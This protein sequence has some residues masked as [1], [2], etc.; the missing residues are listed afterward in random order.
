MPKRFAQNNNQPFRPRPEPR[1]TSYQFEADVLEGLESIALD[2]IREKLGRN[3]SALQQNKPGK[4]RFRFA[5]QPR[6]LLGLQ[7][8][9]A[10]YRSQIF[11]VPRP[12][13]LLGHQHFTAILDM[14]GF[15][16][17]LHPAKAFA[18]MRINAAG[19]ESSV[20]LRLR[21]ELATNTGL[22]DSTEND[23]GDLLIRLRKNPQGPG[24]EVLVRISPRPLG[25]RAW[26]VCNRPAAPNGTL[27]YAM[28]RLS[29]PNA[30]DKLLNIGCG[31]GT[32][33]V[34]RLTQAPV[35]SA[36]GCDIDADALTCAKRNLEAA[37]LARYV[38]LEH[39]DATQ[40]PLEDASVTVIC[41]DLPFGQLS[42]SNTINTRLYPK[43]LAEAGR[44]AA[45]NA[46][47]VLLT[48]EVRLLEQVA[49]KFAHMWQLNAEIAV[50]SSGMTPRIFV[51]QRL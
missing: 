41:G 50:H 18:T 4:I 21:S 17:E 24:W 3:V 16:R 2:E 8:L 48:H 47:M 9:T 28:M 12:K 32:L 23:E 51:F 25:T 45:P 6:Q 40:L 29:E 49:E 26:R 30:S 42:G 14:I 20:M 27:A 46:R 11:E 44:V 10:V 33:L 38:K 19:E 22:V 34:E 35:V 5:G 39:W 31:S 13:A 7:S 43:I 37:N 36:I 1:L 15:A